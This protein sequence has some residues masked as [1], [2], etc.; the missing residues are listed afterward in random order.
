M[1][2]PDSCHAPARL[3]QLAAWQGN[4]VAIAQAPAR[5]VRQ[6]QHLGSPPESHHWW[7][8]RPGLLLDF[9]DVMLIRSGSKGYIS[10]RVQEQ[11]HAGPVQAPQHVQQHVQLHIQASCAGSGQRPLPAQVAGI[12]SAQALFTYYHLPQTSCRISCA[13]RRDSSPL[14]RFQQ[15]ADA[16]MLFLRPV[17]ETMWAS[18]GHSHPSAGSSSMQGLA[19]SRMASPCTHGQVSIRG[20]NLGQGGLSNLHSTACCLP[21]DVTE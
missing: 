6:H 21:A 11:C 4:G 17:G 8:A 1:A 19:S 10:R 3:C 15:P 5:P 16:C 2:W 7:T 9:D 18:R 14:G 20:A 13:G 12:D